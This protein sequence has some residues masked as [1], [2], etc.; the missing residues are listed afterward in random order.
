MKNCLRKK[1]QKEFEPNKPK[2]VFCSDKCRVYWNR[3]KKA[4]LIPETKILTHEE[5]VQIKKAIAKQFKERYNVEVPYLE[6]EI[7][8]I[9]TKLPNEDSV[10]FAGRKSEWKLKYGNL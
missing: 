5:A 6:K 4:S 2:Q 3:E 9:P 10:D 7:P 1:C 8:P